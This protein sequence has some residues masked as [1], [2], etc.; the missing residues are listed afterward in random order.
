MISIIC[1]VS[2]E[3]GF[4][5]VYMGARSIC[6]WTGN[7]DFQYGISRFWKKYGRETV[8]STLEGVGNYWKKYRE[9][10]ISNHKKRYFD[11]WTPLIFFFFLLLTLARFLE[12][13]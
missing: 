6:R 13:S 9:I 1:F 10:G 3:S 4:L 5:E 7:E 12:H 2:K 8:F 11:I